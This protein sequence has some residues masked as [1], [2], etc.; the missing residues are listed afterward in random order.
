MSQV[1]V[2][3]TGF[4]DKDTDVSYIGKGNYIDARNIRHRAID[5]NGGDF[6]GIV[7]VKGN[8]NL[9]NTVNGVPG[10]ALTFASETQTYRVFVDVEDIY[11][12]SVASHDATIYIEDTTGVLH[13]K[14]TGP[15]VSYSST[16]LASA[17]TVIK[18]DL[19]N[20]LNA[21]LG[22]LFTYSATTTTKTISGTAVAG[23]FDVT[24]TLTTEFFFLITN[25]QG[26][27][28]KFA[29][30][31]E[32]RSDSG[33]FT[34]I[35]STQL[36]DEMYV[37]LAGD[38]LNPDGTSRTS[39][40]GV[41]Y[42]NATGYSY[43]KLLRSKKLKFHP[44][45][46]AEM[47][48]ERVGP[49]INIY[50]TDNLNPPRVLYLN[51]NNRKT[52][53]GA[54]NVT[55]GRYDLANVDFETLFFLPNE[56]SYFED[57]E[58]IEGKGKIKAGNK[59][60][61]G[62][63][64]T[65][66][67]V[68][69]DF[70]EIT[71]PF[72]IYS[73]T[74]DKAYEIY[75]DPADTVTN[76]AVKLTVKNFTP[77]IYKYFELVVVEY[78]GTSFTASVV[79]RFT[80]SGAETELVVDHTEIGQE[81]IQ[82]S[83][84]E[85][86]ALTTKYIAV[87]NITQHDN[88][89]VLS[90]LKEQVDY[91][92]NDWATQIEH[93]IE[94]T[95]IEGTGI[96]EWADT[97]APNINYGEYAVPENVRD[98]TGYMIND[99]YRFGIQV[100][101]KNTGK[102]SNAFWVDD[103]RFDGSNTNV[104]ASDNR[105]KTFGG[106]VT[107]VNTGT[108]TITVNN[109][110]FYEG[111]RI[112][113]S[114]TTPPSPLFFNVYYYAINVTANTFQVAQDPNPTTVLNLTT[115]GTAVTVIKKKI[116]NNLAE[117][118]SDTEN[119]AKVFYPKFYNIDLEY[120]VDTNGDG[121][122]DTPLKKLIKA[123]KIVRSERIPEVMATG[124]FS[125]SIRVIY[126]TY[127]D[128]MPI[129]IEGSI[130]YGTADNPSKI[131][132]RKYVNFLSS[133]LYFGGQYEYLPG[134]KIK[135][136][137][138]FKNNLEQ[139]NKAVASS[140]S[141]YVQSNGFFVDPLTHD[142]QYSDYGIDDAYFIEAGGKKISGSNRFRTETDATAIGLGRNGSVRSSY[143]FDL[144]SAISAPHASMSS[145]DKGLYYGQVF[146]DLGGNLKYPRNKELSFYQSVGHLFI[147]EETS[148]GTINAQSVFGGDIF[149]QK[150]YL[151]QKGK[152]P[153]KQDGN[154]ISFYSQ[155][156]R[157]SQ[158][159][160]VLEYVSYG[161]SPGSVFPQIIDSNPPLPTGAVMNVG[162]WRTGLIAW[163][164]EGYD[165]YEQL[166]YD[167][168]YSAVY[169]ASDVQAFDENNEFD[170]SSPVRITWSAKKIT[171]SLKD[172]YRVFK[173]LDFADLDLTRGEI[174]HH[175]VINN[176]FYTFQEFSVQRQYFRDASLVGAQEGTDI[177]VGSGSIL[178][179]PGVELTSIGT[180]KKESVVKGKN[181]NGKDVVYWYNDRLQKLL[182]LAGDGVQVLSDRGLSTFFVNNGKYVSNEFYP[183]S[184]KGV[185]GVWN[186]RYGEAIFTFKY[187]DGVSNKSFTVA[188]DEIKNGFVSFHSYT[189]NIYLPYNNTFFSPDPEAGFENTLYLHDTGL[190][191]SF[192]GVIGD[193]E[194][195]IEFVMNYDPNLPKIF[196][197]I[198]INSELIPYASANKPVY[199]NTK[200]H[201]SYLDNSDMEL[202]EDLFYSTIKNDSTGTGLNSGDT[203]RL[204]GRWI[205]MKVFLA[206]AAGT[207]K[208]INAIVKF[209]PSPRLYNT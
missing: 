102:W 52:I 168:S 179:A 197:A 25:T 96:L 77:G 8:S 53:N 152:R 196:E 34:F 44:Q 116:D 87:K 123:F 175:E 48:I 79:Q 181:P 203:S 98:Y 101:W 70:I 35:G 61:T 13:T 204:F 82:I 122:G 186:D 55:E 16:N 80:L 99:T 75:G 132:S 164:E 156:T 151:K 38:N 129:Y 139:A 127:E 90:N 169:Q 45:R 198:Q 166:E 172:N 195:Y 58:I 130:P 65:E 117:P 95:F 6:A 50:W 27:Y 97:P 46:K 146:R 32:Y 121:T 24:T 158:L 182:R 149:N 183:L 165:T 5:S 23:Y 159:I 81:L 10:T 21:W 89:M 54:L 114:G 171:G 76:K 59:R 36:G 176:S 67:F 191:Y 187:N 66:D 118:L 39:E 109:H 189:P 208:L 49:Q 78:K 128:I 205:K 85:L 154:A 173:P 19:D 62:R 20:I 30:I 161:V 12:G 73:K 144:T 29:Q 57:I 14:T 2:S 106:S 138:P 167:E 163:I 141:L 135:V 115:S 113:F 91:N 201:T 4:M 112:I 180:S 193:Y 133:D 84:E 69:Q 17:V 83:A 143:Y 147:V 15:F 11:N 86:L 124:L 134:D 125:S 120:L 104:N 64:L 131:S 26:E 22:G 170:G 37:L 3:P 100:Q 108:D 74:K 60:Y 200:N 119:R 56:T 88:R 190:N 40:I 136:L 126:A 150:C 51:Y 206:S 1:R 93:S 105:R 47:Q 107:S 28:A 41:I 192:Y 31:S 68:Y 92:L 33:K 185:H 42:P 178:G 145:N 43:T 63:F 155:N 18:A 111:Q 148:N 202:R 140:T 103:I 94:E 199:F 188:Y 177:V 207:Q 9:L 7:P 174:S 184:G 72:P 71:N 153:S 110:G 194:P 209:R 142:A 160:S 162:E 157:N 137:G